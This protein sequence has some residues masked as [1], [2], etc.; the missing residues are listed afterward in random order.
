MKRVTQAIARKRRHKQTEQASVRQRSTSARDSMKVARMAGK[1]NSPRT[2][3]TTRSEVAREES[4]NCCSRN[5]NIDPQMLE[6]PQ[7]ISRTPVHRRGRDLDPK[8]SR[9]PFASITI[10]RQPVISVS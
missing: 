2:A 1:R 10:A 5:A 9:K 6:V 7:P 8:G 4:G 3:A